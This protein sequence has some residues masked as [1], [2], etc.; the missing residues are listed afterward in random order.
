MGNQTKAAG[1]AALLAREE[2]KTDPTDQVV[3]TPLSDK[4]AS[5]QLKMLFVGYQTTRKER[6]KTLA[7]LAE[8][9]IFPRIAA[10][11][12][13]SSLGSSV[14]A[15][16]FKEAEAKYLEWSLKVHNT[17]AA[18]KALGESNPNA[19]FQM[20]GKSKRPMSVN[21]KKLW[22]AMAREEAEI[23]GGSLA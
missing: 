23:L 14:I 19:C 7:A 17:F 11:D 20:I 16:I 22:S 1:A 13:S 10:H 5:D 12:D 2:P 6:G 15:P 4:Q 3:G 18:I 9:K 21:G 8:S